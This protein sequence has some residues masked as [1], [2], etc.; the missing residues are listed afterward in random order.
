[1]LIRFSAFRCTVR[2]AIRFAALSFG[3]AA[4]ACAA[5]PVTITE[6]AT[7]PQAAPGFTAAAS[8]SNSQF[9]DAPLAFKKHILANGLT[10]IVHEDHKAP[11]VSVQVWYHV[12]SKDEV[13]GKTGF[14][15]LFEHLMFNGSEHHD[16]EFFKPLEAAG[17]SE[18]NGTTNVDRTN[19]YETVPTGALDLA[20]W[21]ES[22]RMANLLPAITQAKLDEQRGVV[23]NEKRQRESQP[24]AKSEELLVT[25][26]YPVGHPYSWTTIGSMEDLDRASLD[27]VRSWF[28][29]YYGP[30]NATLVLA[31][32]VT[33]AEALA[34]AEQYFGAIAPTQGI[35]R[36]EQWIAPFTEPRRIE[37]GERVTQPRLYRLWN[38]PRRGEPDALLLSFAAELLA[39]DK[40]SRL[41]QRLVTKE[42]I[43]TSVQADVDANELGSQFGITVTLKPGVEPAK[44]EALLEE[45]LK[46]F[47]ETDASEADVARRKTGYYVSR[48]AARESVAAKASELAG[49]QLFS[50]A[51]GACEAEWVTIR[52]A[53]PASIRAAAR[54][55]LTPNHLTLTVRPEIDLKRGPVT[56][57]V[58][59][60]T[61]PAVAEPKGIRLP[62]LTRFKLKNGIEVFLAERHAVPLV[63]LEL[64]WPY[65]TAAQPGAG[66]F[67][68]LLGMLSEGAAGRDAEALTAAYGALG[69]SFGA[70][71][72]ADSM[73]VTLSAPR[74]Q[75]GAA[76]QL[77][78]DNMRRP[79]VPEAA[80]ERRAQRKLASLAANVA[81][82]GGILSLNQMRLL[83]GDH[84]Y[85]RYNSLPLLQAATKALT[86]ETLRTL[87]K[88]VLRPDGARILVVGDT[89]RESLEPLLDAALGDWTAPASPAPSR[90]LP[91]VQTPKARVVL[92]DQPGAQQSTVVAADLSMDVRDP[93]IEA[94]ELANAVLGGLFTSRLNLNLREDKHWTYG[95][96]SSLSE[97]LGPGLFGARAAIETPHTAAGM[98]EMQ[99]EIAGIAGKRPPTEAELDAARQSLVRALPGQAETSA[100]VLGLY[101]RL[102]SYG[103]PLDRYEG[104]GARLSALTGAQVKAA[105]AK[106]ARPNALTWLVVGDLDTIE[107]DIRKLNLG[108][109]T[110]MSAEG[111]VQR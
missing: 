15:H 61:L 54:R 10:L 55:W 87:A 31:G 53:T 46:A 105:A 80:L 4:S 25:N 77:F 104:Y 49:C 28:K 35:A 42:Q 102:L 48:L 76:L 36:R 93:D 8:A 30:N 111:V 91:P 81:S 20:L 96:F 41:Y 79:D 108:P 47:L 60:K 44:A 84:P 23:K 92:F 40:A 59:R 90:S 51:P 106:L 99:K 24:Y 65:G 97:S 3:I 11:L 70:D 18:I 1:M 37:A 56:A 2:P 52:D 19:F 50:G 94:A 16:G 38:V 9:P 13:P 71:L 86:A 109:V 68:M 89:D 64:F 26:S 67:E 74:A 72:D 62:P 101:Q 95:A 73:G 100:G 6:A 110:V 27:D 83:Y 82:P 88:Q 63:N 5:Q 107:A 22:D 66:Q 12:G 75:L 98:R 58:D 69:A 17:A 57:K 45:E 32:D 33:E 78:A 29:Q 103:L 21:L 43:A 85:G 39:G 7:M 14:A 34:K